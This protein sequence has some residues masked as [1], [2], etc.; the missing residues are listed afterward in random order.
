MSDEKPIG[1]ITHYY[2][3]LGVGI[4]HLTDGSLKVGDTIHIKGS[5][6]D[7]DQ[8]VDSMQFDHSEIEH[9]KKG[10][11]IGVK[12]NEKVRDGDLVYKK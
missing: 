10:Q 1:K 5:S 7:F 4:I 8:T 12:V 6:T 3:K 9:G 11:E 2:S